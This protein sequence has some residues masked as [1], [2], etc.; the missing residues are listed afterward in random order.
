MAKITATFLPIIASFFATALAA[1]AP[2]AA[3]APTS[4]ICYPVGSASNAPV[5]Q[6]VQAVW[7]FQ[8]DA[9]DGKVYTASA[10]TAFFTSTGTPSA[11]VSGQNIGSGTSASAA[12]SDI[13]TVVAWVINNCNTNGLAGGE[14]TL[15][16]MQISVHS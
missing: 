16:D 5:S 7:N 6:E 13:A 11:T 1:P 4:E 14:A 12:A 2:A 8:Y 3:V 15:G 10:L 9:D